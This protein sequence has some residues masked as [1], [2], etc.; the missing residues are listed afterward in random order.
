MEG[1]N[2]VNGK[3][4]A[5][6]DPSGGLDV[7]GK[8]PEAGVPKGETVRELLDS[9]ASYNAVRALFPLTAA[10]LGLWAAVA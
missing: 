2:A 1:A 4:I 7:T 5:K 8:V 6:L 10:V 3:L 9:W